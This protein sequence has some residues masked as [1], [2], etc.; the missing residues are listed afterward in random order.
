MRFPIVALAFA[1]AATA[2]AARAQGAAVPA[3]LTLDEAMRLAEAAHPSVLA[4]EAQLPAAEGTRREADAL[5][6]NNPELGSEAIRRR[7]TASGSAWNEWSV[8]IA[9][10]FETGG[11]QT[12][13]REAADRKSVV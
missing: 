10:P 7:A 3:A 12:H 13:R 2:N 4:R 9:Q 1:L 6:F 11:Q 8:G 5:L